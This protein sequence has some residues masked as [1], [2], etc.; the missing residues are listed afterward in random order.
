MPLFDTY[1]PI[2]TFSFYVT[3]GY[4][5][6]VLTPSQRFEYLP[7][8]ILGWIK[9]SGAAIAVD[10]NH[11]EFSVLDTVTSV[12]NSV[13]TLTSEQRGKSQR[14]TVLIAGVA[15]KPTEFT[16]NLPALSS[17]GEK[18]IYFKY[19][20]SEKNLTQ[21][22]NV[23]AL[24]SVGNISFTTASNSCAIYGPLNESFNIAVNFDD[25][26]KAQITWKVNNIT[27]RSFPYKTLGD[28]NETTWHENF[29]F[30]QIGEYPLTVLVSNEVSG[31]LLSGTVIIQEKITGLSAAKA[32]KTKTTYQGL[33]TE[34]TVSILKG[35]NVT[36]KWYFG[37]GSDVV[38]ATN[39]T[40][41][42][43]YHQFGLI[44]TT[45]EATNMVSSK[46]YSFLLNVSN[47]VEITVPPHPTSNV[48][49]NITCRLAENSIQNSHVV[50]LQVD[51]DS[52]VSTNCNTVELVFTPGDHDI[53]CYIQTVVRLYSNKS[54]FVFEPI[55][56]LLIL[57]IP[58]IELGKNYTV[59]TNISTGNDV[60][61]KWQVS[62][63][64]NSDFSKI[65]QS[66]ITFDKLGRMSVTVNA[67]N[68]ISF[69]VAKAIVIVQKRIENL[70]LT[71][72]ADPAK[73]DV[74]ITFNITTTGSEVNY[75]V[76]ITSASYFTPYFTHTFSDEGIYN[77]FIV[78]TNLINTD[79]IT[80]AITVQIPVKLRPVITC[81]LVTRADKSCVVPTKE[82]LTFQAELPY[83]TNVTFEWKWKTNHT[84]RPSNRKGHNITSTQNYTFDDRKIFNI[85]VVA[86]NKV[87]DLES[88]L[89]I[90][91]LD[92]V[93]NFSI[94]APKAVPVNTNFTINAS[95]NS[96]SDVTYSYDL[97]DNTKFR[98]TRHKQLIH[99][100]NKAG[101]Y[102]IRG[103][104]SNLVSNDRF[105]REIIVQ[106]EITGVYIQDIDTLKTNESA[107]LKWNVTGGT[108]VSSRVNFSDGSH[109][110]KNY[111]NCHL[112]KGNSTYI[113]ET[114]HSWSKS[115]SYQV[116]IVAINL[117]STSKSA[118]VKV[119]VQDPVEGFK[120]KINLSSSN[121]YFTHK[122]IPLLFTQ[123]KGSDV[124]YRIYLNDSENRTES[125]SKNSFDIKYYKE[126]VYFPWFIAYNDIS[127]L[128]FKKLGPIEIEKPPEPI[129]IEGL[130]ISAEPTKF[131]EKTR[132]T[133]SYE[134]GARFE[135]SIDFGDENKTSISE[136]ELNKVRYY[137]YKAIGEFTVT[138]K[139]WNKE[140]SKNEKTVE[141]TVYVQEPIEVFTLD[142]SVVSAIYKKAIEIKFSWQ[143]GSD[144]KVVAYAEK[145]KEEVSSTDDFINYE[146]RTGK[147]ILPKGYFSEP[148]RYIIRVNASNKVS[149][150]DKPL[151]MSV[152]VI[153]EIEG[154]KVL[155]NPYVPVG[156][157]LRAYLNEDRKGSN[158][159]VTWNFG[160]DSP[161]NI[162]QCAWKTSC[163][164]DHK[165]TKIGKYVISVIARNGLEKNGSDSDTVKIEHPVF[166]WKFH[167]SG[168]STAGTPSSVKLVYNKSFSFPTE[169]KYEVIFY[170]EQKELKK[171]GTKN[172]T[173]NV[174]EVSHTFEK[175][176]CYLAK[177]TLKNKV[178]TVVLET[179]IKV[180]GKYSR[181]IITAKSLNE[182]HNS[183][184]GLPLEYPVKFES[185]INN[186]C[187]K[188]NWTITKV[189][190]SSFVNASHSKSFEYTFNDSGKYKI[191]F[192]AYDNEGNDGK[193]NKA[194]EI[195]TVEK[196]VTGLFLF[197]DGRTVNINV[198]F[199]LLW[200]TVG[201]NTRFEIDYDDDSGKQELSLDSIINDF[202]KY[203]EKLFDTKGYKGTIF[204]HNF[205]KTGEHEVQ[206]TV[207][208]TGQKEIKTRLSIAKAPCPLPIITVTGGSKD[209][210]QPPEV[211]YEV[212]YS[213]FSTVKVKGCSNAMLNIDFKWKVFKAD[214]YLLKPKQSFIP[215]DDNREVK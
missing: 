118:S 150:L 21:I 139:C 30:S 15:S 98:V 9:S 133:V 23:T 25:G 82:Q 140:G 172:L 101:V 31:K 117:L 180:R 136:E 24:Y 92:K 68:I 52:L 27:K 61:Y 107:T 162:T 186:T 44:N 67:S 14:G 148:G 26:T 192:I 144:M 157:G 113:C 181:A 146:G 80:Y 32:N 147:I 100:Y 59:K 102:Q 187:L 105:S 115:G 122:A 85:S 3:V 126:D 175:P 12:P 156:Y 75:T 155:F 185:N 119:V 86:E 38:T 145:T 202:G 131:N 65:S 11:G 174:T 43:S 103:N 188:Y 106:H 108:N 199:I 56:G 137:K 17:S 96:G 165:Y 41:S 40:V 153:E 121:Q 39:T 135:C 84:I 212:Q 182:G 76:N 53:H 49:V 183:G 19:N 63:K 93:S 6:K 81:P 169:A 36:Y 10:P 60:T 2:H 127:S 124:K 205:T 111:P 55:S 170:R 22:H 213:L 123:T 201:D 47:P 77:I 87:S 132:F 204:T 42:H 99:Q 48:S 18:D 210:S 130:K 168:I 200:K 209:A 152:N 179:K 194:E 58:P 8:D 71:P 206:I 166:G 189:S 149:S 158:M 208:G 95:I 163:F 35:N 88:V 151:E 138:L 64:E 178:S 94:H 176:G 161:E 120:V 109:K 207:N 29:T 62:G 46:N 91:T 114:T 197:S 128:D 89:C 177:A 112:V 66:L 143:K 50:V 195:I 79:N 191:N 51:N 20:T 190:S 110:I 141:T 134:K 78:A 173:E 104:A 211:P 74:E 5:I 34:L 16:A 184:M 57:E 1:T 193:N 72:S 203:R 69:D 45:V 129:P 70:N 196:S 159:D 90:E 7:G 54:F 37:D 13:V 214:E 28:K 97:G 73:T 33:P 164:V 198:T 125:T 142:N 4:N 116:D 215:P 154:V 83:A 167:S 171:L 160:D